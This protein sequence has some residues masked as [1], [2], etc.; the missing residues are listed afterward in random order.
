M[1]REQIINKRNI[2]KAFQIIDLDANGKISL[3]ECKLFFEGANISEQIWS[4]AFK[5][6]D[7]N[8]DTVI[9][10]SEFEQNIL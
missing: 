10:F 2:L 4:E 1:K 6:L 3:E 8:G 9:S 7:S 5:G